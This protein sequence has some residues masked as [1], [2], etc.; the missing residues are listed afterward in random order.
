MSPIVADRVTAQDRRLR[1]IVF[2]AWTLLVLWLVSGHV[3]WRDEVRA[4]S[5]ALAGKNLVEMLRTVHGEG[6]P[7]IWY[8]L[9]RGAHEIVPVREVL[10]AVAA[11]VGIATG[12]IIAFRAPFRIGVI[13]LILFSYFSAFEYSVIAR[14]YGIAALVMVAMAALY[15]RVKDSLWFG[16][17]VAL[18]AN[19]NV[20]AAILAASFM[21]FRFVELLS[22]Q[23][24][25]AR[26]QWL[27][28][29]GNCVLAL[30]GA[31]LCFRTIYPTFNDGAVSPNLQSLGPG[32]VVAA[33]LDRELAFARMAGFLP[34]GVQTAILMLSWLAFL[35]RPA[36][37]ASAIAAFVGLKFFFF[38]I[39]PSSYRHEALYLVFLLSLHWIAA[40]GVPREPEKTGLTAW[41][42]VAGAWALVEVLVMQ[43]YLLT[44]PLRMELAGVPYSRGAEVASLLRQPELANAIVM[45]DPDPM[46]ETLAYYT[47]NPLWFLRDRKFG[48]VVRLTEQGRK[49]LTLD[50]VLQDAVMLHQKTG[51]PVVFLSLLNL[52]EV[53]KTRNMMYANTTTLTPE[54]V[55]RFKASTR[56]LAD[57][58]PAYTDEKYH[59]Y[60]YPR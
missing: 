29:A 24:K 25:A 31:Y 28:F 51:R 2:I 49:D 32:S 21:L 26:P 55:R 43:T 22:E 14:N 19:T 27:T 54:S 37:L 20:P 23:P 44:I 17:M 7:A 47:D 58:R 36:A 12:A 46:V 5:L 53:R 1:L 52:D 10:P 50:H 30:I 57:L 13:A 45:A 56:L 3:F 11:L 6:H 41:V 40:T 15:P 34:P 35:K 59:V 16:L 60:V 8:L 48:N 38:F 33:I 4:F 39:Y 9:L 42:R 18:L